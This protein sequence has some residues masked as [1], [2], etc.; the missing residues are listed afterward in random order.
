M[1]SKDYTDKL[2]LLTGL[3]ML[4]QNCEKEE[5][6]ADVLYL[7]LPNLFPGTAGGIYLLK[8]KQNG[9]KGISGS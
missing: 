5:A 1:D 2:E 3:S 7:Y 4:L 8:E 6:L 9:P